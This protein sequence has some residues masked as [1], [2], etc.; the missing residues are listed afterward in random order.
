LALT[1]LIGTALVTGTDAEIWLSFGAPSATTLPQVWHSPHRPTQRVDLQPHSEQVWLGL[2]LVLGMPKKLEARSD[3]FRMAPKVRSATLTR[4]QP[5]V[6]WSIMT[7]EPVDDVRRTTSDETGWFAGGGLLIAA[8]LATAVSVIRQWSLCGDQPP[9]Q[10]CVTL[11]A[12]MNMLPIQADT[13]ELRVAWAAALAALGLT[14]AT[15]AWVA[16]LILAPLSRS[17]KIF[18]AVVAIPLAIMTIAGWVGVWSVESWV[19]HGGV[20]IVIGTISEFLGIGFLVFATMSRQAVNLIITRRLVVLLFG[21]TA[22]G[23]MHQSAEFILFGLANQSAAGVPRYLG[24]GTA[25]TLVITGAAVIWM[26][27]RA[28]KRPPRARDVSILG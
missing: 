4:Q 16:F 15:A 23:T 2:V 7:I 17:I 6:P 19:A 13:V 25:I 10:A 20:W 22:F 11:R 8:G 18:G 28:R 9:S 14:L 1:S 12:T 21:V 27:I 24:F 3:S 5:L 26:T